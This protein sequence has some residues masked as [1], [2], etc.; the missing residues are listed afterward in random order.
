MRISNAEAVTATGRKIAA[1][2]FN[3]ILSAMD[4]VDPVANHSEQQYRELV[5]RELHWHAAEFGFVL[6]PNPPE[7]QSAA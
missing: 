5:V 4:Y 1:L 3:A 7:A 6:V 2:L